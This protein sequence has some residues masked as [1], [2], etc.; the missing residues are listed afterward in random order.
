MTAGLN[1]LRLWP[2]WP[3]TAE[4][5]RGTSASLPPP[6]AII[7][8]AARRVGGNLDIRDL[9]AGCTLWLPGSR[10]RVVSI[11]DT[12][13]AQGDGEVC[14]RRLKARWTWW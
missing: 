2:I 1:P 11:G 13:A 12:H 14:A 8:G 9:A 5:L 3:R 7:G 6:R 10:R 4:T